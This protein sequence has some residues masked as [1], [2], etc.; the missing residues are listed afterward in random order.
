MSFSIEGKAAIVTGAASGVGAA[1]ALHLTENGASVMFADSDEQGLKSQTYGLEGDA[2]IFACNLREK[3]DRENLISATIGEFERIDILV[4]ASQKVLAATPLDHGLGVVSKMLQHNLIQHYGLCQSVARAFIKLAGQT[5][6]EDFSAGSI[7][8]VSTIAAELSHP[9]LTAYSVSCAALNQLT[10]SL[11]LSL[12]KWSVRVNSVALGSVMSSGLHAR[13]A[14]DSQLRQRIIDQTPLGRIADA[15]EVAEAVH[16]LCSDG[17]RF[18]TGQ[19]LTIDGGRSLQD[20]A[21]VPIH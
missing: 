10:R 7:V 18:I 8:N 1:I 14:E 9:D 11:A 21:R 20:P 15:K 2:R 4:N 6:R 13:I 5:S 16:F 19:V 12:A 3:L 17:A